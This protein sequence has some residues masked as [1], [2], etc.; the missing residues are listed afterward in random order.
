MAEKKKAMEEEQARL[1]AEKRRLDAPRLYCQSVANGCAFAYYF[2]AEGHFK[3]LG[4]EDQM[5]VR[6]EDTNGNIRIVYEPR[7]A[8]APIKKKKPRVR[9]KVRYVGPDDARGL[10]TGESEYESA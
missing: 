7:R 3:R 8:A 1:D 10:A 2:D 4:Y 6:K 5:E 9:G